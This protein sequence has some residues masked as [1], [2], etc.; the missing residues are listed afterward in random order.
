MRIDCHTHLGEA[1]GRG[2][3]PDELLRSMDAAG[4][5]LSIVIAERTAGPESTTEHLA[6][7][8]AAEPR[9]KVLADVNFGSLDVEELSRLVGHLESGRVVGLKFYTGYEEYYASN[10][11]LFPLYEYCQEHGRP[12][13][14]HTG[15]L[16]R[17]NRGL[18]KYSHPLTIDEV[19]H[20]FP[21]LSIVIA[22]M[23]NPWL[24]D[25]AAVM[26]KNAHVYADV[27]AFFDEFTPIGPSEIEIFVDRLRDV[28]LFL[29]SYEKFLFGTDW[30]L[31][32]QDEYR[33]AVDAL[34]MSDAERAL[35][36]GGNARRIFRI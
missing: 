9:L 20:A 6:V 1:D 34:E 21:S 23:G 3:G 12:V 5:D 25:C 30:P 31:Y 16:E 14:F 24:L 33:A 15:A 19:A 22:H 29:G 4:I 7:L 2:Y 17:A 36:M 18:L 28:R 11:K 13:M 35:V 32:R 27:S 26:S 8:A 10:E